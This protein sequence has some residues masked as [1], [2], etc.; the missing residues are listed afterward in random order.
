M[1]R[2][3]RLVSL[4]GGVLSV[5]VLSKVHAAAIADPPYDLTGG[6]RMWWALSYIALLMLTTYAV[7][8]PDRPRTAAGALWFGLIA[9]AGAALGVS[10]IQ[11]VVGDALLPRFVVFGSALLDAPIQVV[12]NLMA[13]DGRSREGNRDRVLLVSSRVERER[14]LDDLRMDVERSANLVRSM[15]RVDATP[16][17]GDPAPIVRAVAESEATLVVL[18]RTAQADERVIAQAAE[19]HEHGVRIRTLEAFYAGWLGKLPVSELE[20]ASLFFDISEVHNSRFARVKRLMDMTIAVPA[21]LVLAVLIPFVAIGDVVANRGP[22]MYRQVR[23][24]RNGERF[25]ILKFR[26]MRPDASDAAPGADEFASR[27]ASWTQADDPRVTRFGGLLRRTHL[28][29][30]PQVVNI[31]KGEL[32]VVGPRPEQPHYVAELS[33]KLP[34]YNLRHL[35]RPGLTGWAQVKYGYAGDE[36]DALEKLQYEFFYLEHQDTTFDLRIMLRTFRSMIGGE[37]RGR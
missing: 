8:L 30:L 37:G 11:L 33:D 35:V 34:F 6:P 19:L 27:A 22:L 16:S 1:L 36:R 3:A 2:A 23:V 15:E 24:G 21:T 5:L 17:P 18:D 26:T 7:G 13:R 12:A 31:L 28:D 10:V 25:T 9:C 32:S 14:L 4:A 20:R 29:E